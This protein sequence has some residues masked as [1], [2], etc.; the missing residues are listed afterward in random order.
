MNT[1]PSAYND[2]LS[3]TIDKSRVSRE[4]GDKITAGTVGGA[5]EGGM[6][7]S[8]DAGWGCRAVTVDLK[9]SNRIRV[10]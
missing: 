8:N 6:R 7:T 10:A 4:E 1:T 5:V 2:T 9:N 3:C